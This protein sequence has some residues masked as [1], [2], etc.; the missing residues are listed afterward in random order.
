MNSNPLRTPICVD[1]DGTLI[2]GDLL[3][4]SAL[5][6]F[7][8]NPLYLLLIPIWMIRGKA[9]LKAEIARRI[10]FTSTNLP[11]NDELLLY[12]LNQKR[13][14][15]RDLWLCTASN[16][17]L[18][19]KIA[20]HLQIFS[21]VLASN[22]HSNFSGKN[23]AEK[24]IKEFGVGGFEYCGNSYKDLAVWSYCQHAIVVN[25]SDHL[26]CKVKNVAVVK[27]TFV[28]KNA[29]I[30]DTFRAVRMHQWAKNVL[31]FVPLI[32]AHKVSDLVAVG[33]AFL[34]FAAFSLCASSV[35]L[36]NDM[37]DLNSDRKNLQKSKR[38]FASGKLS[39]LVGFV[40]IPILL[41][42]TVLVSSSLPI[43][44]FNVLCIYYAITVSYSYYLKR[45]V[46]FDTIVLASLYAIRIVAGAVAIN[47]PL[48]FWILIFSIFLFY[49]LALV[50]RYA[51]LDSLARQDKLS[52]EGRGYQ[53]RDLAVLQNLGTASGTL[54]VLVMALYINLSDLG[55]HY[56]RPQFI[57]G[58]CVLLLFWI[59]WVWLKA[60]RG[61]MHY[62]PVLFALR[63]KLSLTIALLSI[64]TILA[65]I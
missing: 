10:D 14:F 45:V 32:A 42:A 7:K 40:L 61:E 13:E 24:L 5:L 63:D 36:L 57:W 59:S 41:L 2:H 52:T 27:A 49:S 3:L 55:L 53:V 35:Y 1:L 19:N 50:K 51:E 25:A 37:L 43:I 15:G 65:A 22:D 46:L 6:L 9:A 64:V 56:S 39:L 30:S 21:G 33:Q 29:L 20:E 44:F 58:L 31:I 60:H 26:I 34:A 11:Y 16:Y 62:D 17:R 23:K 4:E 48:S 38:P 28:K 8:L 12:L 18:A 54:S 47:V